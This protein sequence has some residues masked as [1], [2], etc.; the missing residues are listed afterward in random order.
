MFSKRRVRGEGVTGLY[1]NLILT[2]CCCNCMLVVTVFS[3]KDGCP[4]DSAPVT[5]K[6]LKCICLFFD[7]LTSFERYSI[8]SL[9]GSFLFNF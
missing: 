6:M 4:T 3:K 8:H 7:N 2:A 9:L 5:L 1:I